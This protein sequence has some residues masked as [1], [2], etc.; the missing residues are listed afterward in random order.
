MS[1]DT[2]IVSLVIHALSD[3]ID[4]VIKKASSLPQAECH[5]EG[6]Y[7][8]FVLVFETEKESEISS[9]MDEI[10]YWQGVMSVQLCYHHCEPSESL[11]E[12]IDYATHTS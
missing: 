8:K 5:R 4:E 12:E 7:H 2:H 11:L 1:N 3:R 6:Q 9:Y 10:S